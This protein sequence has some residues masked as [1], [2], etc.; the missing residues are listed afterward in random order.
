VAC[1]QPLSNL[2]RHD[3]VRTNNIILIK[4][5]HAIALTMDGVWIGKRILL[6]PETTRDYTLQISH[7]ETSILTRSSL[8]SLLGLPTMD[9]PLLAG[10]R[11]RKLAAI[12]HQPL[13]LLTAV[14]R[15]FCN[16]SSSSL[17]KPRHVPHRKHRYYYCVFSPCRRNNVSTQSCS[18]ATAVVLSPVYTAVTWQCVYV[19]QYFTVC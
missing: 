3:S 16:L 7:T 1:L 17:Y 9:V 12:S 14:S 13:T 15:L 4:Y 18:L 8:T 11:P 5:S 10:S 2:H 19:P 6:D